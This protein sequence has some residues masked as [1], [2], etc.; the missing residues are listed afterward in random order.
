MTIITVVKKHYNVHVSTCSRETLQCMHCFS[1]EIDDD[2]GSV[3]YLCT[4]YHFTVQCIMYVNYLTV[5]LRRMHC[6][7]YNNMICIQYDTQSC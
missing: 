2:N 4:L 3:H 7:S 6:M 5:E 1:D